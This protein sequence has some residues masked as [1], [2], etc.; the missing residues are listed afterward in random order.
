[1]EENEKFEKKEKIEETMQ[2]ENVENTEKVETKQE[3]VKEQVK[4]EKSE[5][6]EEQ[7]YKAWIGNKAETM[8]LNMQKT[9]FNPWAFLFGVFYMIY[10][11]MYL[12]AI[13]AYIINMVVIEVTNSGFVSI[14]LWIVY[15]FAFYP[16][17]KW[18]IKRKLNN[19]KAQNYTD[20]QILAL[21]KEKGGT[22]KIWIL[23]L[24]IAI[25]AIISLVI[26]GVGIFGMLSTSGEQNILTNPSSQ[27]Y[28]Y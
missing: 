16:L 22:S 10:R 18:D 8:Y 23:V 5:I 19:F 6:T 12:I 14:L 3:T 28:F 26:I 24:I 1:M 21:A 9:S 4:E 27:Y 7:L 13:I 20:E 25:V 17:Y 11:K 2:T 15:G